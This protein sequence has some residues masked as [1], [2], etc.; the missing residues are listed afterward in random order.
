MRIGDFF[1]AINREIRIVRPRHSITHDSNYKYYADI[2][3]AE[4]RTKGGWQSPVGY[5]VSPSEALRNLAGEI[6][7]QTL[8]FN[9]NKPNEQTQVV[10]QLLGGG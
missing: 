4:I 1:D 8:T 9:A 5:G 2:P 7:G 10:P 3:H 6:S